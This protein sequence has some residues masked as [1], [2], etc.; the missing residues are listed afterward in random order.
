M[1]TLTKKDFQMV[2]GILHRVRKQVEVDDAADGP[3]ELLWRFDEEVIRY[4]C[5]DLAATNPAFDRD[6]FITAVHTG[7]ETR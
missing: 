4:V 7:K 3:P 2:A 1:P 5:D 6:R